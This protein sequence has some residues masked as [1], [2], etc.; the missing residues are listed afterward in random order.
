MAE[1]KSSLTSR[2]FSF[3]FPSS[4]ARATESHFLRKQRGCLVDRILFQEKK[5]VERKAARSLQ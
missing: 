3:S 4:P 5:K 2:Y 1:V